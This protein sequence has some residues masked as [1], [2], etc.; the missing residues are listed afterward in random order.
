MVSEGE[1]TVNMKVKLLWAN[2]SLPF[3]G[4]EQAMQ[5]DKMNTTT[6]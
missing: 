6:L 4:W 1:T 3:E 5:V 2:L